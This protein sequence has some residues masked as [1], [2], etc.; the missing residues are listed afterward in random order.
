MINFGGFMDYLIQLCAKI[1]TAVCLCCFSVC[2]VMHIFN[3]SFSFGLPGNRGGIT[4]AAFCHS[5]RARVG[6]LQV[7]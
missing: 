4:E 1:N 3:S 7:S 6:F 2:V 5:F